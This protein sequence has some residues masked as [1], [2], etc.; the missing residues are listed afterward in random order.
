MSVFTNKTVDAASSRAKQLGNDV[1]E[2]EG[3]ARGEGRLRLRASPH[4]GIAYF[5]RYSRGGKQYQLRINEE[6]LAE[7]RAEG[8]RLSLLYRQGIHDLHQHARM[9]AQAAQARLAVEAAQLDVLRQAEEAKARQGTFAQ[10]LE[11]Y[12]ADMDRRG[13]S[14]VRD[15][16][17]AF[18]I[19]VLNAF[20]DLVAKPAKEVAVSDITAVLRHCRT[21]PV[22][23]KGRGSRLTPASASNG[24]LR[25]TAKLRSYLAAAFTFGLTADNDSQQDAGTAVFGLS[26]NPVLGVKAIE[27]ANRAE[28]WALT[29][30]ELK[31]VLLAL[32]DL[33]E[34]H[35]VIA[36]T[37]LYA[38]GQR[39]EM[40]CRMT[41]ADLYD[42]GEHGAVMRM[43]DLKGGKGTPARIHLLPMT[44]RLSEVMA[45]L[46]VLREAPGP[47][48]LR[49]ERVATP[50]TLQK[51]FSA[52]GNQL[53]EQGKTR[54]FTWRH[55]RA[56]IET[57]LAS[58]GVN[59]ERRAWLL[60]HGRS[61]VQAKHYDRYSYLPEKRQD[62]E[63][64]ARYLDQLVSGEAAKVVQL[65]A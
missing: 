39:V 25:Q 58:L 12:T 51:I 42:D 17:G 8:D 64:W 4:G 46:L 65:H 31:E 20:P 40:L 48:S 27:G 14:S 54:R 9:E 61:G 34:R 35:R 11:A 49:G 59:Q 53:A 22:A 50:G 33:P 36:K 38:A 52:M 45:P 56:T 24:K 62:L 23:F 57:H 19:D 1:W 6:G 47:F 43:W 21:R 7:A 10:L 37:M 29:K 30:D 18:R 55:M 44:A 63:K 41:W 5:F 60:S 32:E 15:V 3:G 28:T 26:A 2:T 13:K 16:R